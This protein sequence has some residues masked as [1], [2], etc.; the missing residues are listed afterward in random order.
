M[1][2]SVERDGQK[3]MRQKGGEK[4]R[5]RST[6]KVEETGEKRKTSVLFCRPE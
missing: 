5:N 3:A 1:N 2:H 4:I 6:C